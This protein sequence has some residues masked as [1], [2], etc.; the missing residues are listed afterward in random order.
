VH[1]LVIA[2][3]KSSVLGQQSFKEQFYF[4]HPVLHNCVQQRHYFAK[5]NKTT[6][7]HLHSANNAHYS[8]T[9]VVT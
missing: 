2:R 3:K 1:W 9:D 5:M 8:C 4:C 7:L 6:S